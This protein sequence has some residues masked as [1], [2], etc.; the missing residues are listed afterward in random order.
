MAPWYE[1]AEAKLAVTRTGE[2][3][4]LPSSNNYKVFEAGAKAIGYTEVSTGRMAI[5]SIDNDERPACQQT[6][7]CFQGCKWGAK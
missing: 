2:F 4:G 1:K 3:P 7:F 5:N 6:G